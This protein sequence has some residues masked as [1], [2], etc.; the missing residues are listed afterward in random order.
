ML[1][2]AKQAQRDYLF[3]EERAPSHCSLGE[4]ANF[5]KEQFVSLTLSGLVTTVSQ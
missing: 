2:V 4:M 5:L 3:P 1:E